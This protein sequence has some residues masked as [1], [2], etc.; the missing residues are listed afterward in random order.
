MFFLLILDHSIVTVICI[1]VQGLLERRFYIFEI[2]ANAVLNNQYT[3]TVA[4]CVK[5]F[6]NTVLNNQY[7]ITVASC[8]KDFENTVWQFE[9]ICFS[10]IIRCLLV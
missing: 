8:V 10:V 1:L 7:S 4:S 6:E 3:I 9:W 2:S 5:D